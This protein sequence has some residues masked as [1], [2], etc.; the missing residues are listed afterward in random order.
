MMH[1]WQKINWYHGAFLGQK[2]GWEFTGFDTKGVA[3]HDEIDLIQ[4]Q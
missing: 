4:A 2:S 1:H 3:G